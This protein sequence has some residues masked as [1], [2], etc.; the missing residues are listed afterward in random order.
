MPERLDNIRTEQCPVY[1]AFLALREAR[2]AAQ[3]AKDGELEKVF[4]IVI[5][6]LYQFIISN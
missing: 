6:N 3:F 5:E 2:D 1:A 4:G